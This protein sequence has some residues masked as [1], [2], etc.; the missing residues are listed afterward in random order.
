ML[1]TYPERPKDRDR[2]IVARRPERN[3]VDSSRPVAFLI[4]KEPAESGEVQNVATIFLASR[5]CPWR[6]LMCDLWKNT[7]VETVPRGAIPIQIDHALKELAASSSEKEYSRI[8][9]RTAAASGAQPA[10]AFAK[11][12]KLYNSGSFFDPRAIPGEDYQPIA[13]RVQHFERVIVECHP[14]LVG[15]SC[16]RFRDLLTGQ[17]EVAMGLET[18]HPQILEKLNKRMTLDQF[19]R[20]AEFLGRHEIRL[21]TFV[22]LKPP[23]LTETE[24]LDWA[25]RS[26]DFAFDCGAIVVSLIPTRSGNGALDEL[27]KR[28]QFA[29]PRLVTLETALAYGLALGRGRVFADLWDVEKFSSCSACFAGRVERLQQ[30]N[31]RQIL[32]AQIQ[33]PKCES[34]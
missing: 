10:P 5:E 15:K 17:L 3:R 24:A 25:K 31:L 19:S 20:A 11:R 30:M 7:L 8:N 22:L 23:F 27:A 32:P 6:C 4:E 33:C 26:I 21:R 1:S 13:R 12:I 28:D 29:P 9:G 2:W 14:A 18:A 34:G 16:L